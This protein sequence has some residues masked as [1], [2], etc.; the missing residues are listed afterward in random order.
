MSYTLCSDTFSVQYAVYVAA[1]SCVVDRGR[2]VT[3][4]R[5]SRARRRHGCRWVQRDNRF[6]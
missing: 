3:D 4:S 6:A 1:L 2:D 5:V